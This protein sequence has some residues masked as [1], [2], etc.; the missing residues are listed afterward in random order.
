[1]PYASEGLI[2]QD[3]IQGGVEIST[4]QYLHALEGMQQGLEVTIGSG[5]QVAAP[6]EPPSHKLTDF[7]LLEI[8]RQ[9]ESIWRA[10]EMP[11]AL[12]CVTSINFGDGS[13]P[14]TAKQWQD[15]WLALR[16]WKDG[17]PDFPDMSKRPIRPS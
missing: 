1:M 17:N 12:E 4:Q 15:Y 10:N 16:D 7:E 8:Q 9:D 11:L 3:P 6:A 13:I 5:F 2:S 14:G